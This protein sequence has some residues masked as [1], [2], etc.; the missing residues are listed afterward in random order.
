MKQG[1][2]WDRSSDRKAW[3]GLLAA[4]WEVGERGPRRQGQGVGPGRAPL[5]VLPSVAC[6]SG[7]LSV[8]EK[9]SNKFTPQIRRG[10]GPGRGLL[11]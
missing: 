4:H 11:Q 7:T 5:P 2:A 1:G 8:L 9:E 10:H 3:A 6:L